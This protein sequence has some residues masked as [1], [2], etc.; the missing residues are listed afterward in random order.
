MKKKNERNE[1]EDQMKL[2]NKISN[3]NG[4]NWNKN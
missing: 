3:E 2:K 1:N 4:D